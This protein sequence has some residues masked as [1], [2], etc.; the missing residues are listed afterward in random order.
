MYF[1]P[2]RAA[3]KEFVAAQEKCPQFGRGK[4]VL[5]RGAVSRSCSK[6]LRRRLRLRVLLGS[7]RM[8]ARPVRPSGASNWSKIRRMQEHRQCARPAT[9]SPAASPPLAPRIPP[10][11]TVSSR[12]RAMDRP[13]AALEYDQKTGP[14]PFGRDSNRLPE[15]AVGCACPALFR[16]HCT[17][18]IRRLPR[19]CVTKP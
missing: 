1:T 10:R 6:G 9:V 11:V 5:R 4:N 8:D 2:P 13:H 12:P 18:A 14:R 17:A 7:D 3:N 19:G 16:R 15:G